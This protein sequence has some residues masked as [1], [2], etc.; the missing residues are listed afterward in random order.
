MGDGRL[1][2]KF[3]RIRRTLLEM[4]R[5]RGFL[6]TDAEIAMTR[7]Q[8]IEKF[9]I[10]FRKEVLDF[11]R[12]KRDDPSDIICV[13]F[14]EDKLCIMSL[15]AYL[16]QMNSAKLTRAIFVVKDKPTQLFLWELGDHSA[17]HLEV[18]TEEELLVNISKNVFVPKHELLTSPKKKFLLERYNVK[19]TQLPRIQVTDP[20]ARYYG[21][22]RGDVVKITRSSETAG[23][24][25]TYRA[26]V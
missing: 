14:V 20:V 9:G 23:R 6:V 18:F 19:I 7:E 17:K 3:F 12:S 16:T 21:L 26:A 8:F 4:L 10:N 22:V 13:F 11:H 2:D 5:D 1:A 24:Y 15:E 25:V